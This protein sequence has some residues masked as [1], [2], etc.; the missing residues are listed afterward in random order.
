MSHFQAAETRDTSPLWK[1]PLSKGELPLFWMFSNVS[2]CF[3]L[4]ITL[5][6]Y[7][8]NKYKFCFKLSIAYLSYLLEKKGA[9]FYPNNLSTND[10]WC[11]S[12]LLQIGMTVK[13]CGQLIS[14]WV[15]MIIKCI[16]YIKQ[17]FK[18]LHIYKTLRK[19][20]TITCII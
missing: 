8:L 6:K 18:T 17:S 5:T 15:W 12:Y 10:Y 1:R 7:S 2:L 4:S 3:G 13:M 11:A 16:I 14:N 9:L 20:I 19:F